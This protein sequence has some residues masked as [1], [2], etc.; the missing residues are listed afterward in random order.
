[1][2]NVV[3]VTHYVLATVSLSTAFIY[4]CGSIHGTNRFITHDMVLKGEKMFDVLVPMEVEVNVE[5][6]VPTTMSNVTSFD[7]S[8]KD[9]ELEL[10]PINS[11]ASLYANDDDNVLNYRTTKSNVTSFDLSTK[12]FE[13]E[14]EPIIFNASLYANDDD[15]VLNYNE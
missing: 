4:Q 14:L 6:V 1:M 2:I 13:L 11:N 7:L 15:N 3:A 10:E 8:T 9:F 12:D 5:V